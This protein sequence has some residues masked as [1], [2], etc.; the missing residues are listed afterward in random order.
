MKILLISSTGGHL[1]ALQKLQSFW[2]KHE[3]CWV[4]FKTDSTELL[5]DAEKVYWAYSPTNRNIPNLFKNLYLAYQ[6]IKKEK[7]Q[8]VLSTGAGIA[9]PFIIMA[10][11]CGVKTAFIESFT[12]VQELSLSAR[13]VLP[14]LDKLYVQWEELE[15]KYSKAELIRI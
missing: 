6:V 13:L 9:V 14:F 3:C 5:L 2:Q 1:N 11:F 7:P 15:A 12:R 10:K 8:L 4:T